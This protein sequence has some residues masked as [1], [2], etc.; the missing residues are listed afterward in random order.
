MLQS[1]RPPVHVGLA[2]AF[3]ARDSFGR[4][5]Q[6]NATLFENE[7]GETHLFVLP[8]EERI[9]G[10]IFQER[11]RDLRSRVLR[12]MGK[13]R[14][15]CLDHLSGNHAGQQRDVQGTNADGGNVKVE[16]PLRIG[17]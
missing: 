12:F 6:P 7:M 16:L 11:P 2:L 8:L 10:P 17:F 15:F 5:R 1:T 14:E 3:S 13:P 9:E 4:Q